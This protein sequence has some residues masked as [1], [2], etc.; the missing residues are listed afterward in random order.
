MRRQI[1][2][3]RLH[4]LFVDRL[5]ALRPF[6]SQKGRRRFLFITERD[7]LSRTQI[8]PYFF[9]R[10]EFAR[11]GIEIREL[12]L[13]R[14]QEGR[15]PYRTRVDAVAFQS[16]F[17]LTA[18]AVQDLADRVKNAWPMAKL[19]YFDWFAPTDLRYAAPLHDRVSVYLKK[20]V[21]RDTAAYDRT[22]LG[23][24]N[25]TDF[26][27]RRYGLD[28]P[29]TRFEIPASFWDKLITG[30]H[31]AFAPHI[32]PRFAAPFPVR[33]AR[34]IDLHARITV[35]GTEWYRRM[36]QE[37]QD[38]AFLMESTRRVV[39]RGRIPPK[40]YL[41]E[42]FQSKLCFSPFGY[43]E[44]CWRDFEAMFSGSLLLKPD[45][46]HL[47]CSPEVFAPFE[48]YVPLAWDLG[49][50]RDKVEYY[51]Q[52]DSERLE[53]ARNAFERLHRYFAE[54]RFVADLSPLLRRLELTE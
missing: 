24:T 23:E 21:L 28:Y 51:L 48:T 8:F 44:I 12:P 5:N 26:F 54:E 17:D 52:H 50:L 41:A 35:E 25:L 30:V 46:S 4:R 6:S 36:R 18:E 20:H 40:A 15:H 43:G 49:D 39:G 37:S 45:M 33:A 3:W 2:W 1:A 32:L 47:A 9:H 34:P 53:I 29:P 19:A 16:W 27:A 42:L 22:T 11:Q 38:T 13:A 31:F 14:F 10:S 7:V